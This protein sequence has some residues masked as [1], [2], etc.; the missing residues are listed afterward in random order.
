MRELD[1]AAVDE[2]L[3]AGLPLAETELEHVESCDRC[4]RL[5]ATIGPIPELAKL[6]DPAPADLHGQIFEAIEEAGSGR[7]SKPSRR[8][9]IAGAAVFAGLGVLG[10]W[11]RR[12]APERRAEALLDLMI[13]DHL[14]YR[15]RFDQMQIASNEQAEVEQW[16]R[17][18]LIT[19]A[20]VIDFETANVLGA[21]HCRLGRVDAGLVFYRV[22]AEGERE[23]M[24]SL[25]VFAAPDA[26]FSQ[27]ERLPAATGKHVCRR[28]Q[29]G[30]SAAI[31]TERGLT[32][33]LISELDDVALARLLQIV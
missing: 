28:Q 21:R 4:A 25:Y 10:E 7:A 23:H 18:R 30:L 32:Y 27:M 33:T 17:E 11:W 5:L 24:A 16:L 19:A 26:D 29:L 14:R 1:C 20:R 6:A 22:A 12:G 2:R 15:G 8:W 31:W 3:C 13:A 9:F